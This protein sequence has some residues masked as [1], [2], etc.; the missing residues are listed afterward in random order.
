MKLLVLLGEMDLAFLGIEWFFFKDFKT[1]QLKGVWMGDRA[2][3]SG[4]SDMRKLSDSILIQ[5]EGILIFN[6][7]DETLT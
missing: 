1:D 5:S 6:T 2:E 3:A 7:C 4:Q